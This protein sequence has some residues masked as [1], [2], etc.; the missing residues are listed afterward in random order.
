MLFSSQQGPPCW[1]G[2]ADI[3]IGIF[4]RKQ[5]NSFIVFVM[6]GRGGGGGVTTTSG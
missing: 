5:W 6:V 2:D 1:K 3:D 4:K